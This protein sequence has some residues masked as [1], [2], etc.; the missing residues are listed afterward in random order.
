[1]DQPWLVGTPVVGPD[2]HSPAIPQPAPAC[3][4]S[5][6]HGRTSRCPPSLLPSSFQAPP[7]LQPALPSNPPPTL[8]SPSS[9]S[10]PTLLPLS[11]HSPL[12]LLSLSSHSPLF[13]FGVSWRCSSTAVALMSATSLHFVAVRLL[14]SFLSLWQ[15]C[16]QELQGLQSVGSLQILNLTA[17]Y[18]ARS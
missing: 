11:S 13:D 6:S 16:T 4:R 2:S 8:L 10:P 1:M 5:D 3:S 17:R 7:S 15:W 18:L 12:T 14:F 9:N